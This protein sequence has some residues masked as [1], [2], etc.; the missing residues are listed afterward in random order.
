M[1]SHSCGKGLLPSA[2]ISEAYTCVHTQ[3]QAH[4]THATWACVCIY[5]CV[6]MS[7]QHMCVLTGAMPMQ[8][9][10]HTVGLPSTLLEM[11]LPLPPRLS[12]SFPSFPSFPSS[13]MVV[14]CS[15]HNWPCFRSW[16][17]NSRQDPKDPTLQELPSLGETD[18]N[19]RN[20]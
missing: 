7:A 12:A 17:Y 18:T 5:A 19:Q 20:Q 2:S 11:A 13:G 1:S 10:M 4:T 9:H 3:A 14:E 8:T 6:R 16:G 15:L